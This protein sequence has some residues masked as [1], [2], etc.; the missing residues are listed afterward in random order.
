[1][2]QKK[3]IYNVTLKTTS[4]ILSRMIEAENMF[5]AREKIKASYSRTYLTGEVRIISTVKIR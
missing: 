4:G 3:H 1:M 5:Q 2:Q